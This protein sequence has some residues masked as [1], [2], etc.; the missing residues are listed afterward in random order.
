MSHAHNV[1]P[2]RFEPTQQSVRRWV[3]GAVGRARL[4]ALHPL[5]QDRQ[6]RLMEREAARSRRRGAPAIALYFT[7]L[8]VGQ[9]AVPVGLHSHGPGHRAD[10]TG[11]ITEQATRV[12]ENIGA[13]LRPARR[14]P[15]RRQ[16]DGVR[17]T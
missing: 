11:D 14:S 1:R 3:N 9:D 15:A 17:R 6:G 7:A 10:T 13:L 12:L 16:D 5:A 2:R 8:R 4:H